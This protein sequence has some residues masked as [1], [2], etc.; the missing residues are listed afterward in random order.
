MFR[1]LGAAGLALALSGCAGIGQPAPYDSPGING[2][3]IPTP[4]ADPADFVDVVDNPWLALRPGATWRYDVVGSGGTIGS[5]EAEVLDRTST[6]AGLPATAVRTDAEVDGE[7]SEV[8]RYYAQDDDGN[9]WL[10]GMDSSAGASW[11]AGTDGA[12]AGLAMP[13]DPRLGDGWVAYR[14]PDGDEASTTIEDQTA[15][16][17]QVRDE[18]GTTTRSVYEKGVG[19]VGVED[20]D[21]G[22][23]AVPRD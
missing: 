23:T 11:R 20:L 16:Q 10:V 22:W 12:E 1:A 18:A 4:S 19:L 8:T 15:E 3:V 6:V 5:I 17:V 14:L 7:T 9:V 2:L 21:A 13:G